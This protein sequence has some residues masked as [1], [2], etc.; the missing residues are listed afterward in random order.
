[1][2]TRVAVALAAVA[3][4]LLLHVGS[5]FAQQSPAPTATPAAPATAAPAVTEPTVTDDS[6]SRPWIRLIWLVPLAAAFGAA[7]VFGRRFLIER[8]WLDAA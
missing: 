3:V 4:L 1:M 5:A 2:K 7:A 6:E 8:E